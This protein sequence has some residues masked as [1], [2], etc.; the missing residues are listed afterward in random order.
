MRDTRF[1]VETRDGSDQGN[2]N[3]LVVQT[4]KKKKK[5]KKRNKNERADV[6]R[7]T[8]VTLTQTMVCF[9]YYY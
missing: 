7:D 9:S 3:V 2:D 4:C 6:L 1:D 8:A 5:K